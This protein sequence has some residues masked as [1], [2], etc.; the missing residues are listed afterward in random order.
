MMVGFLRVINVRCQYRLIVKENDEF[1]IAVE[2]ELDLT[3][4]NTE[5][6]EANPYEFCEKFAKILASYATEGA[7]EQ[8]AKC[9]YVDHVW[10]CDYLCEN[11][12]DYNNGILN[13]V[14]DGTFGGR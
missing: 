3:G 1:K 7:A 4:K 8:G 11:E 12:R 10:M 13:G 14:L 6:I 9:V 5:M 2:V